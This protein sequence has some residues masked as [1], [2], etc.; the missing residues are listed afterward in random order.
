[1]EMFYLMMHL[2]YFIYGY[3]ESVVNDHSHS[4]RGKPLLPHE[5]LFPISSKGSFS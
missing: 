5:L 4:N 3:M 1:M 2:T